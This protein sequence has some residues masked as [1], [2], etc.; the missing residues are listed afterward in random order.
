MPPWT[1]APSLL[2]W[3]WG[4]DHGLA[5]AEVESL[6]G[7]RAYALARGLVAS[8]SLEWQ[9]LSRL[10]F[11]RVVFECLGRT[12]DLTLPFEPEQIISGTFA[13]RAHVPEAIHSGEASSTGGTGGVGSTGAFD[14]A[15]VSAS[16]MAGRA[17]ELIGLRLT[18]PCVDLRRPETEIHLFITPSG[19]YWGRPLIVIDGEQFA[20][21][22]P[23]RRPF[24]RSMALPQRKARCLVNLSGIGPGKLLL[25]P[26]CGTGSIPIEATLMG[27]RCVASDVDPIVARGV[28]LNFAALKLTQIGVHELDARV[29]CESP[30]RFDGIVADLPYGRS[31]SIKGV[32]R[33]ELYRAFLETAARILAPGG[34]VVLMAPEGTLPAEPRG[35]RVRS[36][37]TEYVHGSLTRE[38]TVLEAP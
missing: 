13:V 3:L 9:P 17:G 28:A 36:R 2:F 15:T 4:T 7:Q 22:E 25:D 19:L 27:I 37:H 14:T 31:A 24:W 8:H 33:D 21:R 12:D 32:D 18:R 30:L 26:F 20:P 38:V 1:P 5:H 34:R 35:L 10:A 23:H 16:D 11:T 29:W 6:S